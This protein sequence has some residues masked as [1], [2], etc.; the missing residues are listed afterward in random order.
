MNI[1]SINPEIMWSKDLFLRQESRELEKEEVLN[2]DFKRIVTYMFQSL[3][4]NPI[5]VGLAAP[6]V[7][8]MIKLVVI[9]IKRNAKKPLILIN[10]T[11]SSVSNEIVDSNETCLSFEQ[12]QGIVHRYKKIQVYAKDIRFEDFEFEA[13]GFLSFV[14]QHE[15]DHLNGIVYVDHA[16]D[17][18]RAPENNIVLAEKV[19]N[20][21]FGV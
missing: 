8:L 16:D 11:Y 10:P 19:T 21:L 4:E 5:G 12:K 9:D 15:I 18:L 7:G 14:C 2:S 3:Y 6:Q 1:I 13:D 20:Q 17:I